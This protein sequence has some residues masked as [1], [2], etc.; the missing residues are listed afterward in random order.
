MGSLHNIVSV[1]S[2]RAGAV[3]G[4]K[5]VPGT[6]PG[7]GSDGFRGLGPEVAGLRGSKVSGTGSNGFRGSRNRFQWFRE[8]VTMGSEVWIGSM[9]PGTMGCVPLGSVPE[10]WTEPFLTGFREQKVLYKKVPDSGDSVPKVPKVTL[11]FE[12]ILLHSG[13]KFFCTLKVYFC[14]LKVYF[15]TSKVYC[16]LLYFERA[17]LHTLKVYFCTSK[18]YCILLYFERALLHT[19]KVYFCTSKV[20]FC[21]LKVYFCT[22][23]VYFC[24]EDVYFCTLKVY[25]CTLKGH[26]CIL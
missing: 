14:T 8:P 11:Y 22:L 7:T 24:T 15:C 5:R 16:I 17:L 6:V 13:C 18:V 4:N 9:V 20:Y 3:P 1:C 25:F 26:F 2:G 19:L 23:K 12:S 21:N 10:V